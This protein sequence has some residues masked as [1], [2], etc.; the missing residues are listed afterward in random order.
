MGRKSLDKERKELTERQVQWIEELFPKLNER[1]LHKLSM[2]AIAKMMGKSK[3]TVY[4]YFP[5][6]EILVESVIQFKLN[7]LANFQEILYSDQY[8][9]DQRYLKV[10]DHITDVLSDIST[11]LLQDVQ[12]YFPMLWQRILDFTDLATSALE[13][14]YTEGV[15][16]GT[17]NNID[18]SIL[19]LSDR[20]FFQAV[21]DPAFLARQN[22]SIKDAFGQYLEM[23]FYG[24]VKSS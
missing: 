16:N 23:K 15:K 2:N 17:Y 3:S 18:T 5:S 8:P 6:K 4:E 13:D 11:T 10:M 12:T 22:L 14:H 1:G 9:F 19:V 21:S 20:I 24:M 7:Q